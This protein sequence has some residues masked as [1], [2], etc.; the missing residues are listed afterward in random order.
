MYYSILYFCIVFILSVAC[1]PAGTAL[2]SAVPAPPAY[3]GS[4]SAEARAGGGVAPGSLS[5]GVLGTAGVRAR[6]GLLGSVWGV[7]STQ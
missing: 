3:M 6:C 4:R 2:A 7:L 5:L 1:C